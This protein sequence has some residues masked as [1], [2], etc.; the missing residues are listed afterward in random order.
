LVITQGNSVVR[1]TWSFNGVEALAGMCESWRSVA[2]DFAL[3]RFPHAVMNPHSPFLISES[4][5]RDSRACITLTPCLD[6]PVTIASLPTS[7]LTTRDK[8]IVI[9]LISAHHADAFQ[10]S[11]YY[12]IYRKM[13][14]GT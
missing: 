13:S 1:T 14:L 12:M 2:A 10:H 6:M 8:S 5:V 4:T 3:L 11:A 7:Y 9:K